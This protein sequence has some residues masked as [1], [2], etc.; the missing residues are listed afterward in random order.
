LSW[1]TP[2]A[3]KKIAWSFNAG[4]TGG[5][6]DASG[7]IASEAIMIAGITIDPATNKSLALQLASIDNLNFLAIKSSLYAEKVK[8]KP[9]GAGAKEV[10]LVGPLVLF[11]GAIA[12]LGPSLATL[13]ITNDDA[14]VAADVEILIGRKLS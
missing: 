2:V 11:G 10:K 5:S 1:I 12:L 14:A 7:D 9:G 6:I 3:D 4:S 8:V 13:T